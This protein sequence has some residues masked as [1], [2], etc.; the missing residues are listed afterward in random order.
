VSFL[1]AIREGNSI[2]LWILESWIYK[3]WRSL[4]FVVCVVPL[5]HAVIVLDGS[6]I[7]PSWNRIGWRMVNI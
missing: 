5:I 6:T 7:H 1:I 3:F 2:S 4:T